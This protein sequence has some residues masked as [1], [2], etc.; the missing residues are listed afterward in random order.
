VTTGLRDELCDGAEHPVISYRVR[1]YLS[2]S[3]ISLEPENL[4]SWTDATQPGAA[5]TTMIEHARVASSFVGNR[6][7]NRERG[8]GICAE[9]ERTHSAARRT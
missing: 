3:A 7:G 6:P 8:L 1:N 2:G 4:K 5:N 9:E